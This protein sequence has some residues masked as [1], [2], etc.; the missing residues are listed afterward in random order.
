MKQ[1]MQILEQC[2]E[3]DKRKLYHAQKYSEFALILSEQ[4]EIDDYL[5]MALKWLVEMTENDQIE[6]P[7]SR[8]LKEK[9]SNRLSR[10]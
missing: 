1:A 9:L 2:Y 6:S 5:E 4:Y 8:R 3:N 7:R 10:I